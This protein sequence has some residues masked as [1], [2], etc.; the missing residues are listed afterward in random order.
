MIRS[1]GLLLAIALCGCSSGPDGDP[2]RIANFE[3]RVPS[4]WSARDASTAQHAAVDWAPSSND[5]KES[6]SVL[7]T[8][9]RPAEAKAGLDHVARLLVAGQGGLHGR[10]GGPARFTT[11]HGLS[12]VRVE[13]EFV[14]PGQATAYHRI[15]AVLV[16]G[17]TIV[18]VLYT[19][20]DVDRDGFELV[21][22][23][24]QRGA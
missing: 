4:G 24:F 20:R 11:K 22:D 6:I 10:F 18:H 21:V 2:A 17:E 3:Y 13:G 9:R 14:P 5:R 15:H 1:G 23:S 8:T 19:A 16:D 12:G 7:L